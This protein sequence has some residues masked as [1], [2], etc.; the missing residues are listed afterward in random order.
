MSL[1]LMVLIGWGALM[2][3]LAVVLVMADCGGPRDPRNTRT[4]AP[5]QTAPAR[6]DAH[7]PIR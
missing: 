4:A 3:V 5:A 7:E 1:A 6:E 2:G